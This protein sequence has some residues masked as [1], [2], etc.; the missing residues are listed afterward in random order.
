MQHDEA[1]CCEFR[2]ELGELQKNLC[3]YTKM[4]AEMAEVEDLTELELK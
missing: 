4:L 3:K 1:Y 2:A